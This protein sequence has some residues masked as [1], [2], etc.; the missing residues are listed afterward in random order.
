MYSQEELLEAFRQIGIQTPMYRNIKTGE[1]ASMTAE[2][3]NEFLGYLPAYIQ[4]LVEFCVQGIRDAIEEIKAL[5]DECK[6]EWEEDDAYDTHPYVPVGSFR[7]LVIHQR[8]YT[9]GFL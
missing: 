2:W 8:T 7:P 1:F 5:L 3:L 9:T 4:A 6:D